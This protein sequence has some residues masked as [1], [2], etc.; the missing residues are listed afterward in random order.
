[1]WNFKTIPYDGRTSR[2]GT[3]WTKNRILDQQSRLCHVD[4]DRSQQNMYQNQQMLTSI[5]KILATMGI[6]TNTATVFFCKDHNDTR[7]GNLPQCIISTCFFWQ[8]SINS[9]KSAPSNPP[10]NQSNRKVIKMSVCP[11]LGTMQ[12]PS[13][14]LLRSY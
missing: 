11:K 13:G 7:M 9:T 8:I 12:I 14:N 2:Q 4:F 10:S 1:M 3:Q 6:A 5:L